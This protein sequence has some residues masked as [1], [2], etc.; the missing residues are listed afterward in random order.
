MASQF[1]NPESQEIIDVA[2]GEDP[3]DG[4]MPYVSVTP[5]ADDVAPPSNLLPAPKTAQELIAQLAG[6]E[7]DALDVLQCIAGQADFED[8]NAED[9]VRSI[10][11]R[12]LTSPDVDSALRQGQTVKADDLKGVPLEVTGVRWSKSTFDKGPTVFAIMYAHR[13]DTNENV[14]VACGGQQVM[15]QLWYVWQKDEWPIR[16]KIVPSARPTA[17]GY[18]PLWLEPLATN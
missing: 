17:A 10:M 18:Y 15:T 5:V 1:F 4:F 6:P 16:V 14:V 2:D 12:I 8:T 3:P 11:A 13:E 7:P 9:S